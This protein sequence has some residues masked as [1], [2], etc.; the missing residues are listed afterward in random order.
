MVREHLT[1]RPYSLR[2]QTAAEQG[3]DSRSEPVKS[4]PIPDAAWWAQKQ[5][6]LD[7]KAPLLMLERAGQIQLP[8]V[9]RHI[10]G[11]RRTGRR[12]PEAVLIDTTPLAVPLKA[13]GPIEIAP[14][15]P[16]ADE[17]LFNSLMESHHYLGYEQPV[18]EHLKYLVWAHGRPRACVAWR[19]RGAE[20]R[21]PCSPDRVARY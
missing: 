15:R 14:V 5:R 10:R 9:R 6:E 12:R 20:L 7:A 1:K 3:V 19:C 13:L 16:T 17:P 18:G 8:P 21:T 2:G 11:Q 4:G